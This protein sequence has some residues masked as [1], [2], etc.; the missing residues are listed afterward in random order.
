ML[1]EG[2]G[3]LWLS[4]RKSVE[5]RLPWWK[6]TQVFKLEIVH[7]HTEKLEL[8]A[9]CRV[10]LNMAWNLLFQLKSYIKAQHFVF[11][12]SGQ[13]FIWYFLLKHM[14]LGE[15]EGQSIFLFLPYLSLHYPSYMLYWGKITEL[16]KYFLLTGTQARSSSIKHK[17]EQEQI[18]L[19]YP[20]RIIG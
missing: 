3:I 8:P 1:G 4:G 2:C 5:K 17:H 13:Q 15:P 12:F 18:C 7:K 10:F 20:G 6:S 14:V 16:Q 11:F 19:Y 9:P